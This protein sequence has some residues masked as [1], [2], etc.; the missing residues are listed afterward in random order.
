MTFSLEYSLLPV[1]GDAFLKYRK[2]VLLEF[3][4]HCRCDDFDSVT[5]LIVIFC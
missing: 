2:K 4:K 5:A 1:V 3:G